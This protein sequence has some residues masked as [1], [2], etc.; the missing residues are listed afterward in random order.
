M[1][2]KIA[3]VIAVANRKGGAGKTT[4]AVHLAAGLAGAH[5]KRVLLVDADSQGHCALLLKQP[6]S[7]G[8]YEILVNQRDPEDVIQLIPPEVY[9]VDGNEMA[10]LYLLPGADLT[11]AIAD[12]INETA[13]L[14]LFAGLS[15]EY[16]LD[17]IVVDTQPSMSKLDAAVWLVVDYFLY[18][19]TL[20]RLGIDG[21]QSAIDQ[22]INFNPNRAAYGLKPT[23]V[24]GILPNRVDRDTLVSQ[25]VGA[26]LAAA[27]Q[28]LVWPPILERETWRRA[29]QLQKMVYKYSP[30]RQAA[31]NCWQMVR[32]VKEGL[33]ANHT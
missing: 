1:Q 31:V 11:Y 21:L 27:Y 12:H 18:V 15:S 28:R 10:A 16:A 14:D 33:N 7:N 29:A 22:L 30:G 6:K 25:T 13:L 3:P 26:E 4:V 17:V 19:T 5:G 24:M 9:H 23:Q 8:L 32:R 20:D 2:N